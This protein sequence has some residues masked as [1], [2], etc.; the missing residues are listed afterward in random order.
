MDTPTQE[1][2]LAAQLRDQQNRRPGIDVGDDSD[3]FI[4]G[5]GVASAAAGLYAHQEHI[6]RQILPDLADHDVLLRHAALRGLTQNPATFAQG[7]ITVTGAAGTII[8]VATAFKSAGG[9][10]YLTSVIAT[11]PA[12]GSCTVP[13]RPAT[14]GA[15]GNAESGTALSNTVAVAGMDIA[16]FIDIMQGGNDL[17]DDE[18]LRARLLDLIRHPPAGGNARDFKRWAEEV[19][20]VYKAFV[21]PTRRGPGTVDVV[22][23]SQSGPPSAETV[24]ACTAHIEDVRPAGLKSVRIIVPTVRL[25]DFVISITPANGAAAGYY[26]AINAAVTA[27]MADLQ[28]GQPLLKSRF[29][30]IVSNLPGIIDRF[31]SA[32][33]GNIAPVV[34]DTAMQ[35]LRLG[36]V[37]LNTL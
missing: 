17:E 34:T 11:I 21:Y 12:G 3:Y 37:N 10:V 19:P 16:G 33:A 9:V 1:Q 22:I 15:A 4:R 30:A 32:P 20:G 28:P 35:W 18:H 5:I 14:S 24:A 25:V 36:S 2:I 6:F 23:I 8:P 13:A 7:A 31:I 26:P 29:E 27:A